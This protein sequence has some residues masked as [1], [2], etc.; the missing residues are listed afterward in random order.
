[1]NAIQMFMFKSYGG[2]GSV[3]DV[4]LQNFI[5]HKNAYSLYLNGYWATQTE[6]PGNGVLYHD[7]TFSNWKGTCSDGARCGPIRIICP[8]GTPYSL[9][10]KMLISGPRLALESTTT[11][12]VPM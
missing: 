8:D 5:G 9:C 4:T 2:S 6:A 7:I 10:L 1:M 12:R 11:A 3:Y